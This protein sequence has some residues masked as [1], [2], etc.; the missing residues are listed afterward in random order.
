MIFVFVAVGQE[1]FFFVLRRASHVVVLGC[2]QKATEVV[3]C[4]QPCTRPWAP[5]IHTTSMAQQIWAGGKSSNPANLS[6]WRSSN[7]PQLASYCV[8]KSN[9]CSSESDQD[10]Q[11]PSSVRCEGATNAHTQCVEYS[12]HVWRCRYPFSITSWSIMI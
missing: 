9:F 10:C 7:P 2:S 6:W 3:R 11:I 5:E 1:E 12:S 4:L 8:K